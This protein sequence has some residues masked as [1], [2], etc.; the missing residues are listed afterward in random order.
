VQCLKAALN[1]AYLNVLINL[2]SISDEIYVAEQKEKAE[3]LVE[4]GCLA[5]DE[6][7]NKVLKTMSMN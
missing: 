5:A 2:Y 1:S 3:K 6:V 7:Y 4:E